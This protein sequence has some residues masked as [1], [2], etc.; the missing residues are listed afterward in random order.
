MQTTT[1]RDEIRVLRTDDGTMTNQLT[2][3]QVTAHE[4]THTTPLSALRVCGLL[5]LMGGAAWIID[6]VTIAVLNRA[7]DPLDSVLFLTGLACLLL[8]LV[9]LA[10]HLSAGHAGPARVGRAT[11]AFLLTA[12]TLGGVSFVADTLGRH[13]FSPANIGLHGEWS[14]FI[15]GVCLLCIAAWTRLQA[16]RRPRR[17]R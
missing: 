4:P 5:A 2:T 12:V 8:T 7:F 3:N 10:T 17:A 11:G 13:F 14:C 6:T 15:T 16:R 9:S 1:R